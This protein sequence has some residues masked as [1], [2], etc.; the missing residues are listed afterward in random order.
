MLMFTGKLEPSIGGKPVNLTDEPYSDRRS[1]YGYIDRGALPE[2]MA[3]FDF[4]D[5]DMANS[6]RTSTIVPQQALFFMN[7]PMAVDVARK[8]TSRPE[9]L[10]ARD[11]AARVKALYE[12][13]FQRQPRPTEVRFAKEFLTA[14]HRDHADGQRE[15]EALAAK[16]KKN[17]KA[18]RQAEKA[19]KA[20]RAKKKQL[21][22]AQQ[23]RKVSGR[24][25]IRNEGELVERVPLTPW[26][27]YAQALLFSNEI[28]YVN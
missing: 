21:Q 6:S 12:V 16:L 14:A 24:S 5:P 11:D 25:A 23:N 28:V 9:F 19:E 20:K 10:K 8:A 18:A 27:Q 1:V 15:A 4:A 3:Q 2:L 7:S 13:L 17:P 26:E 22:A